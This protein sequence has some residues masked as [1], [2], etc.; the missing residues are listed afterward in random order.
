MKN[1]QGVAQDAT[2]AFDSF[3]TTLD[4][5]FA[6]AIGHALA[7]GG[8]IKSALMDTA[9]QAVAGLISSLI[10]LGIQ[11][12]ISTTI[13][14]ALSTSTA[15]SAAATATTV[16]AAW[17][18]AAAFASLAT[19]G[20]NAV[21]ADT[22]LAT[23]TALASSL[24]LLKFASG[25]A[26]YGPGTNTSDS[27]PAL[28]SNGEFVVNAS[29]Y[30]AHRG[31][32]DAINAG[33]RTVYSVANSSTAPVGTTGYGSNGMKIEIHNYAGARVDT[34]Q[35]NE[36]HVRLL[37]RDEVPA[38]VEQHADGAVGRAIDNPNSAASKSLYRNVVP[39]RNR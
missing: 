16:A 20:S 2:K 14:R 22:A 25:G 30:A 34:Q 39:A 1:Y 38:L 7:F 13:G 28:L 3:F 36:G 18:P 33:A 31:A 11:W 17:A 27:I 21:A 15:A 26:V 6:D 5:G 35:L 4:N 19:L 29:A 9:R 24:S 37:I 12:V 8:S 32:V 23:T 10:K